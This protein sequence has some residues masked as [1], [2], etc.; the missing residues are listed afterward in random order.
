[1]QIPPLKFCFFAVNKHSASSHTGINMHYSYEEIDF[2]NN[3]SAK[4][5]QGKNY[6]CL[7]HMDLLEFLKHNLGLTQFICCITYFH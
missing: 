6:L 1:M 5:T 4:K 7:S 3:V 2:K